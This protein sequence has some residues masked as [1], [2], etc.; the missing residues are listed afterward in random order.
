MKLRTKLILAVGVI[1][2]LALGTTT[3]L[4]IIDWKQDYLQAI[5]WRSEALTQ[6]IINNLMTML[7]YNPDVQ[8][9][10]EALG[11]Q[12]VELYEANKEKQV[13]HFAV[14]SADGMIAA[15][16]DRMLWKTPVENPLLRESLKKQALMTVLVGDTYHTLVPIF[17]PQETYIGAIDVG[18]PKHAVD[19][20]VQ[21]M[22]I[23]SI[24][25]FCGF[26]FLA[27]ITATTFIQIVISRPIKKLVVLA[28]QLAEGQLAFTTQSSSG[29]DEVGVMEIAFNQIARYVQNIAQIASEIATGELASDVSVRSQQDVLG[30]TFRT[31]VTYLRNTADMVES[32]AEGDL[33]M[34][35]S[36]RSDT[37][38][39]GQALQTMV[40]GLR[41]LVSQ[42]RKGAENIISTGVT[43][44]NQSA[45]DIE[46][47]K[48]VQTSNEEVVSTM[49][50]IGKSVEEVTKNMETLSVSV[51]ETSASVSQ[52]TSSI[53]H[54]AL[55]NSSLTEQ[56]HHTFAELTEVVNVMEGVVK[57][58]EISTQLSQETIQDAIQGQDVVEQ[59]TIS[60]ETIHDTMTTAVQ[61]ITGFAERSKDIGSIL[62]V[63][64][65]ITDQT[66]LLALNAAIIAAQ[67]G[68]HGRG[69][70]VVADEIKSLADGVSASTKDIAAI[71]QTLQQDTDQV[72]RVIY[73][74]AD[75]V[76]QGMNLT[77]QA[78]DR[79]QKILHSAQRSSSVVTEIAETLQGVK[80]N[81]LTANESMERMN[82]MIEN[83]AQATREQ[84]TA[85][86]QINSTID[87][88]NSMA[89]QIFRATEQQAKGVREVSTAMQTIAGL[90]ERNLQSSQRIGQTTD[91]LASQANQLIHSVD[92]FKLD[93]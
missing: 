14:I 6:T 91:E 61:S 20:Q 26:L 87:N 86:Q 80:A 74:G 57:S 18:F 42:I 34:T 28:Q 30:H 39:F 24:L 47:V 19:A 12:C 58:T 89:A 69:F 41:N 81:S 85:T 22:L 8:G 55:N 13:A 84:Q 15:H 54:I 79:L 63:I 53:N 9:L 46:I 37:D 17:D 43:I 70:A 50:E 82:T 67:A 71:L 10:L 48:N 29:R 92:R 31:M 3:I 76:A 36:V 75:N 40:D 38:A 83:T 32:I 23:R 73:K 62:G 90:M 51:E 93:N 72:V 25:L 78:R 59:M 66:S 77:Q 4:N 16:N 65:D 5:E 44:S 11:L 88:L 45:G 49:I 68:E 27:I 2:M 56:T 1:I 33:T 60:I 35:V 52:M 64:R 7:E 21:Q